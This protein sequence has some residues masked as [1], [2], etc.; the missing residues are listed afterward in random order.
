MKRDVEKSL[1]RSN[2]VTLKSAEP[3]A[4]L[5]D[6][7]GGKKSARVLILWS[8]LSGY[9]LAC[10]RS[11]AG[12]PNLR[13]RAVAWAVDQ[14]S[15]GVGFK[16]RE[17]DD[18]LNLVPRERRY[19]EP[20]LRQVVEE[21]APDAV[22]VAGWLS[23]TYRSFITN[24]LPGNVPVIMGV[25]TPWRE[26]PRQRLTRFRF[27]RYLHRVN[28][29]LAAGERSYAYAKHLG[30]EDRQV[31][32]GL[33]AW[34]EDLQHRVGELRQGKAQGWLFVGRYVPEKGVA[35]LAAAYRR[36]RAAVS[37]PWPLTCCGAGPLKEALR[38]PGIVD[39]GFVSPDDLPQEFAANAVFVLPSVYEPWGVVLAEAMGCGLPAIATRACGAAIDLIRDPF[40]GRIVAPGCETELAQAMIDLHHK[41]DQ[42]PVMG[43]RAAASAE[44]FKA[45]H[46]ADKVA[47]LIKRL[48]VH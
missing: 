18:F 23:P 37:D 46:W 31:S 26:H 29:V 41:A 15:E 3:T 39:R 13:L 19:D 47:T 22:L 35:T 27:R 2:D 44:P 45:E 25:D 12:L 24:S 40:N 7:G 43:A 48:A 6:Q 5:T 1:D 17:D 36:Y 32:T 34:D 11:L 8:R 33:Y 21:Y 4:A 20:Y 28:H 30:F 9:S 38:G 16:P 10:W 14:A 42:L